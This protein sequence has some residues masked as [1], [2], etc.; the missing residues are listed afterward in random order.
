MHGGGI[1]RGIVGPE[2]S[3]G[4]IMM[5]EIFVAAASA[6]GSVSSMADLDCPP[7]HL[8]SLVSEKVYSWTRG[9]EISTTQALCSACPPEQYTLG[10]GIFR[11]GAGA[12]YPLERCSPCPFGAVCLGGAN[13]RVRSGFWLL[14]VPSQTSGN[15]STGSATYE[16]LACGVTCCNPPQAQSD[17][18]GGELDS[19]IAQGSSLATTCLPSS[20]C[21]YGRSG[22]MCGDCPAGFSATQSRP[23]RCVSD[24]DCDSGGAYIAVMFLVSFAYASYLVWRRPDKVKNKVGVVKIVVYFAQS[25]PLVTSVQVELF[26]SVLDMASMGVPSTLRAPNGFCVAPGTRPIVATGIQMLPAFVLVTTLCL[27]FAAHAILRAVML[28]CGG[29]QFYRPKGGL[30]GKH[31]KTK[32]R[33]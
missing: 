15:D 18:D 22:F 14:E 3:G 12:E 30:F 23:F 9:A 17:N 31:T 7:G 29:S 19:E 2:S 24:K 10:R 21:N 13:V 4:T 27:I 16:A 25:V 8:L 20:Q 11:Q 26:S 6:E 32:G 33:E 1:F 28:V 5:S